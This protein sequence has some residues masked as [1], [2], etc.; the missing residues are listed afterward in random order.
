MQRPGPRILTINVS[1]GN[2]YTRNLLIDALRGP[3]YVHA[4]HERYTL[5]LPEDVKD[6]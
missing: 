2:A 5:Q 4:A 3:E 6:T 1:G